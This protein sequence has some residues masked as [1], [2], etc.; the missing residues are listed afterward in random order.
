MTASPL[1]HIADVIANRLIRDA[2]LADQ[3][4][5]ELILVSELDRFHVVSEPDRQ[6]VVELVVEAIGA[7]A[8]APCEFVDMT[9]VSY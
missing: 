6:R 7:S 3:H 2:A 9:Q 5:V 1:H 8:S 4:R